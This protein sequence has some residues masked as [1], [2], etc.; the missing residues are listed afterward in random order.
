MAFHHANLDIKFDRLPLVPEN[1]FVFWVTHL[2]FIDMIYTYTY[3]LME[4][5]SKLVGGLTPP[6]DLIYMPLF[7]ER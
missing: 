1:T 5:L 7:V 6:Q 3:T 4:F 2:L